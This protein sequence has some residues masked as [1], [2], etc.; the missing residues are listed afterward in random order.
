MKNRLQD[1][2]NLNLYQ[3]R[4]QIKWIVVICSIVIS[5][6]SIFYTNKLVEE[7]KEREKRQIELLARALEYASLYTDN[8]TFINQEIIQQNTSIPVIVVDMDG[9][10][11]EFRNIN[12]RNKSSEEDKEKKLAQEL[13][14]MKAEYDPI[15]IEDAMVYYRNSELLTSLKFYPYVQLSVILVFGFLAYAVFNQSKVAEQNRVWAGLTKETAHQLG[16]PIASLMAWIDYL[17][18]SPVWDENKEVIE[19]MDKDVVKLRMVTERFSSIGSTPSI[20][21]ENVFSIIDD[22]I[23]YLRPRISSKVGIK[24]NGYANNVEALINKPLF[25][26]VIENICKNAVDAM[27]GQGSISIDIIKESEKFV[28]ID[29]TD[30]GKGMDKKMFKKVFIPGFTTRQR[31]WGLGLTLAK[32]I[33]EGYHK[34]KIFVKNSE[35]GKGTT[36]RIVL[37]GSKDGISG[38]KREDFINQKIVEE[39]A[40][41]AQKKV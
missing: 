9:R 33:I 31:G 37:H 8:L 15:P 29:I 36:F 35:L 25:E 27:K 32:R 34:G 3:N 12:F 10:P 16:T 4:G 6:G 39:V 26:W 11:I 22:A 21:P 17:R 14:K 19:E 18:N 13:A 30:T 38:F 1:I 28:L 20:Q 24:I 41:L 7:L 2:A 23:N 40:P 5:F